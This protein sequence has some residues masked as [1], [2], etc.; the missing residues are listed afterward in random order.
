M[1]NKNAIKRQ[2]NHKS[3]IEICDKAIDIINNDFGGHYTL[4]AFTT[5][6]R[7][8][9]GTL[10]PDNIVQ[11]RMQIEY[12]S[13]GKSVKSITNSEYLT[14][15]ELGEDGYR[16]YYNISKAEEL[17]YLENILYGRTIEDRM[18]GENRGFRNKGVAELALKL[19]F[20]PPEEYI[21]AK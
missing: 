3:K 12:M 4:M 7:F 6:Y 21:N 14:Y 2:I 16:Q 5:G 17:H 11:F 19:R 10:A 13:E 18:K 20:T 15:I 8:C 1:K 9:F